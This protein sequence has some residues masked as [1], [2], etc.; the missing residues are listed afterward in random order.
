MDGKVKAKAL[1]GD[2]DVGRIPT[3]TCTLKWVQYYFFVILTWK[4]VAE[5]I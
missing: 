5:L 4:I 2:R 1:I 3:G